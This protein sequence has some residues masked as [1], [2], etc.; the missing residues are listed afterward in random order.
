MRFDEPHTLEVHSVLLHYIET[1][2]AMV[3]NVTQT[4]Y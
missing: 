1:D 2:E 3:I 4:A